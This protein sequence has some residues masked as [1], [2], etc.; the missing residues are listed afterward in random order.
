MKRGNGSKPSCLLYAKIRD[1]TATPMRNMI[2]ITLLGIALGTVTCACAA[3]PGEASP[4]E[5]QT[6]HEFKFSKLHTAT[7]RYLQFVPKGYDTNG[8]KSWPLMLFLHGAGERGNDIRKVTIHGPPKNVAQ[9][10]DFPFILVSPQCPEGEIWS[11]ESLLGL[12][13]KVAQELR[14]D[15]ER[16]YLTGLSM[17]GYGTWDL[18]LKHP[19]RFAAIVPICGGGELITLLL[20]QGDKKQAIQSLGVWAFHGAKDPTVPVN[21]SQR[22]IDLLKK[23]GAKDARLTVYPEAGHDSWTETYNNPELYEWLLSHSRRHE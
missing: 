17:G 3:P 13:D 16:V 14:V 4:K 12:L 23:I 7:L 1:L 22:M 11:S 18:G 19:E 20:A 9:N 10:P 8:T 15:P 2:G 21:E 6:I 5:V